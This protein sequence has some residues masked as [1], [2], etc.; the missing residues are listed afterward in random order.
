[1]GAVGDLIVKE[2][3]SSEFTECDIVFSGLDSDIAGHVGT[4]TPSSGCPF[5]RYGLLIR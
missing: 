2:C 5:G 3:K 1:M 4:Q